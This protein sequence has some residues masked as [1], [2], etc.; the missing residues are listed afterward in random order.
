MV[1]WGL[2]LKH[3]YWTHMLKVWYPLLYCLN[4]VPAE[5]GYWIGR[6]LTSSTASYPKRSVFCWHH[7]QVEKMVRN[8][9]RWKKQVTDSSPKN[10]LPDPALSSIPHILHTLPRLWQGEQLLSNL[11]CH[12]VQNNVPAKPRHSGN[13]NFIIWTETTSKKGILITMISEIR[14]I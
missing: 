11:P 9:F 4:V 2:D 12:R 5:G 14:Y 6:T 8:K 10:G 3:C 7:W 13:D 1:V